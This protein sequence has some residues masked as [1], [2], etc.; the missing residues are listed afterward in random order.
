MSSQKRFK[1]EI[2]HIKNNIQSSFIPYQHIEGLENTSNIDFYNQNIK[3]NYYQM[4]EY[5]DSKVNFIM[6]IN[7]YYLNIDIEI[8]KSYPFKPPKVNVNG[9]NY[10]RMILY[11][12]IKILN[13]KDRCLHCDSILKNNWG[14]CIGICNI[15][16][17]IYENISM[18]I[19][20]IEIL[21]IKKIKNKYILHNINIE[22][23]II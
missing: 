3:N 2:Q 19:N 12:N 13:K 4:T 10:L 16:K 15:I 14:V 1:K 18:K 22:K 11:T 20:I 21:H 17:E 5:S 6:K 7:N 8:C 23:Y 9:K